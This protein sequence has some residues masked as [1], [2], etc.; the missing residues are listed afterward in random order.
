MPSRHGTHLP[1]DSSVR[2]SRKY[3]AT[4]TIQVCS[5]MTIIPPE[6]IIEPALVSS[7]K[8]TFTS[9]S[10]A[11]R[12]PPDGPPVCTALNFLPA[13][14]PPP[15]LYTISLRVMPMGTS[16]RPV[17]F[18]LPTT[19]KIFVPLLPSVPNWANQSAPLLIISG[20]VAHVSTLFKQ[21]GLSQTPLMAVWIYFGLG[22]PTLPSNAVI[23]AL[24]SP[25]TKAPAPRCTL[26]VKSKPEPRIFS[27]RK[28]YSSACLIAIPTFS[29]ARGYSCRN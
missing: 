24:D 8:S 12:H 19:E 7:S 17:L 15:T 25:E 23:R 27:P 16:T 13:G 14:M 6:P 18:I 28:P 22:S 20:T 10:S 9:S 29:T 5:S 3:L 2:K 11:G 26:I 4:S 21:L 1:H